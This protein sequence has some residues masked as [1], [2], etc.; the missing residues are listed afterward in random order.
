MT[1]DF[2]ISFALAGAQPR[3]VN[4]PLAVKDPVVAEQIERQWQ[5]PLTL[6]RLMELPEA[7]WQ[8][9][10]TFVFQGHIIRAT[11]VGHGQFDPAFREEVLLRVKRY[12][13][14]RT[15]NVRKLQQEVEALE[16]ISDPAKHRRELIPT[17]VKLAV[18]ERDDGVC[19]HCS[20]TA[21]LQFDH[22]IPVAKGGANSEAN[23]QILCGRC[24]REKSSNIV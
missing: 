18:Y 9:I 24:N 16:R 22:I 21:D 4:I 15:R 8:D 20:A 17:A 1:P 23:I 10:E 13:L 14:M 5:E 2:V 7:P 11:G 19:R 6:G 12:V 3:V